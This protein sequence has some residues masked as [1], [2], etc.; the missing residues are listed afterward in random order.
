MG[1][2]IAARFEVASTGDRGRGRARPTSCGR[3]CATP[4]C[5]RRPTARS[6]CNRRPPAPPRRL[7]VDGADARAALERRRTATLRLTCIAGLAG[8]PVVVLPIAVDDGLPLGVAFVGAPGS[9]HRLL[10]WVADVV[11]PRAD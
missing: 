5:G 6:S 9:D 3:R 11:R 7:A 8:A 2:G 1:P 4:S 10:R